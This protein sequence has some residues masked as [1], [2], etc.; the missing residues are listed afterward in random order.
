MTLTERNADTTVIIPAAGRVPE[1][2]MALSNIACPA[3]IPVAGR[4]VIYWTMSY[5]LSLGL[6]RFVIAVAQR[7]LFVEDFVECT[8]GRAAEVEF[9]VPQSNIGVGGTML[10]LLDKVETRSALAV[11][12]DTHFQFADPA[13]LERDHPAV[14]VHPVEESYRW[15]IA[16][17]D[18]SGVVQACVDKQPGLTGDLQALIGVYY[19]P[20][21]GRARVAA[22]GAVNAAADGGIQAEVSAILERLPAPVHAIRAGDWLDCGNPDRQASSHRSLL[23]KRAFNELSVDPVL[24]TITKRSQHVSKFINEINYLRLLPPELSVLFPRLVDFSTDWDAP[25]VTMEYY[26]YPTLSEM[27]VFENVEPGAWEHIFEHLCAIMTGE[28]MGRSQPLA[29]RTLVSMYLTKT[30]DRVDQLTAAPD[31]HPLFTLDG[32]VEVNGKS[33]RTL[34]ELWP[35]VEAAVKGLSRDATGGIIHGDLCFSNILYDLRAQVVKF[36]DARGSFG[37]AGIYGDPRYDVA[38]LY[39]SVFGLYDFIVNDLFDVHV[40]GRAIQLRLHSRP[41][42]AE[43]ERRFESVFFKYF[44]RREILLLTGLLFV[45]MPALHYDYPRRQLAM[46]VRGLQLLNLALDA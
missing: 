37:E 29:E 19:F 14:L 7:G 34:P 12:G 1:N 44:D 43:I 25:Y 31:A 36:I 20:D 17:T 35:E 5:L 13:V 33:L 32:M 9:I 45:S 21:V 6:R 16:R 26:G 40:D 27:F 24:G 8:F 42:H 23:Q 41:Q 38:K 39:H 11:L 22:S 4:P 30:R 10:E 18:D 2:V 3:M 15:C 28:L 46:Y